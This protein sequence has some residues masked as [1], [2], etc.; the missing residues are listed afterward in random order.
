MQNVNENTPC[1]LYLQPSSDLF[2]NL[3]YN[4][5]EDIRLETNLYIFLYITDKSK[6]IIKINRTN[7][8]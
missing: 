4:L 1:F 5:E 6:F 3:L 8:H 2:Q 7:S